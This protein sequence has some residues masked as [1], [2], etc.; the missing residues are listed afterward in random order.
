MES[1][2]NQINAIQTMDVIVQSI[3]MM[4]NFYCPNHPFD[5]RLNHIYNI[6]DL[7]YFFPYSIFH[8][9]FSSS[10]GFDYSL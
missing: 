4:A 3:Y 9:D 10:F 6:Y 5:S 1:Y 7:S 2:S 8:S